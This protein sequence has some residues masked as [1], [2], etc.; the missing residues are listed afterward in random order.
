ME[1]FFNQ[2][3][4]GI[5]WWWVITSWN[6]Q[7]LTAQ[8]NKQTNSF[9]SKKS[10]ANRIK[11][12]L[13]LHCR[14]NGKPHIKKSTD[15]SSFIQLAAYLSFSA[16]WTLLTSVRSSRALLRFPA[17]L[18]P[19]GHEQGSLEW[20]HGSRRKTHDRH[21]APTLG[22]RLWHP[23]VW[24]TA[25]KRGAHKNTLSDICVHDTE[26]RVCVSVL[27]CLQD[28]SAPE[29][30]SVHPVPH[31]APSPAAQ[32]APWMSETTIWI[33][34]VQ[35]WDQHICVTFGGYEQRNWRLWSSGM[36]LC[37]DG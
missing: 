18:V 16:T 11:V 30:S 28:T 33:V 21:S 4:Q 22:F 25:R 1:H 8:T 2:F 27:T 5:A 17:L 14:N 13:I 7:H 19:P 9:T 29:L 35:L 15:I 23:L 3:L 20:C 26:M 32:N 31:V 10:C 6:K 36:W 37:T 12:N 24:Q 34:D